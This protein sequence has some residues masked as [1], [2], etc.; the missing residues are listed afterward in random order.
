MNFETLKSS[1]GKKY[2]MA[3]TG[4]FLS[5]FVVAHLL[6]NL[7]IFLGAEAL[8]SYAE[9]LEELPMLLW[10]ARVILLSALVLHIVTAVCLAV[11]NKKARPIP[12]GHQNTVQASYASLTMFSSGIL[13]LAF[14]IFHLLHFTFGVTHPQFS[15]LV[16]AKGREDVYS[17]VILSFQDLKVAGSY[18]AAMALLALHLSHGFSSLFQTLGL[19]NAQMKNRLLSAG[20]VLGALIFIGY[21]SIPVACLLRWLTPNPI[22][23]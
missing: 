12:Y 20:N 2:V 15:A 17:M 21:C 4:I 6:G 18:M 3:V 1:L 19:N 5:L 22:G 11:E 7:Q 10:P 14:I 8:N 13:V 9:H 23:L 16:D